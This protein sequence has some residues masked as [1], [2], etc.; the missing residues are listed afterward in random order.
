[1]FFRCFQAKRLVVCTNVTLLYQY[2]NPAS[3]LCSVQ[4]VI[5]L[6]GSIAAG[7]AVGGMR[8]IGG[9][10][11]I[12]PMPPIGA[13]CCPIGVKPPI[14]GGMNGGAKLLGLLMLMLIGGMKLCI[15]IPMG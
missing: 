14:P 2:F 5:S 15:C 9:A 13:Y 4:Q 10:G 11:G 7:A 8:G 6:L 1:M 12:P 3:D